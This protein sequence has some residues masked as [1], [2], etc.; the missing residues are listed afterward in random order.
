MI[1]TYLP[2]GPGVVGV[3]KGNIST[4]LYSGTDS[5]ALVMSDCFHYE[6]PGFL[7]KVRLPGNKVGW[8][9][10][11]DGLLRILSSGFDDG[12]GKKIEAI[13]LQC[14]S[15]LKKSVFSERVYSRIV[16]IYSCCVI[17]G[18]VF[19]GIKI[20]EAETRLAMSYQ[21]RDGVVFR[22]D[23][24]RLANSISV[25]F[26]DSIVIKTFDDKGF[27]VGF[28]ARFNE[29]WKM[30]IPSIGRL[31][32]VG[33]NVALYFEDGSD[34]EAPADVLVVN[35]QSGE[36]VWRRSF[37][38]RFRNL[39]SHEGLLYVACQGS[40][41]VF[42]GETGE[43]LLALKDVCEAQVHREM[44]FGNGE[45]V[46]F[47]NYSYTLAREA[48]SER[49]IAVFSQKTSAR[50][51]DIEIPEGWEYRESS[52]DAA[53]VYEDRKFYV[54]IQSNYSLGSAGGIL[55]ID[56]DDLNSEIRFDSDITFDTTM[57]SVGKEVECEVYVSWGDFDEIM[58][59]APPA[60]KAVGVS[61]GRSVLCGK[62]V[63]NK[64]FNGK[65]HL[66]IDASAVE[67]GDWEREQLDMAVS[68][69]TD[70][71]SGLGFYASDGKTE[72]TAHW[73]VA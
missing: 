51:L 60:M 41:Y 56:C 5:V 66:V 55:V 50:I 64:K 63:K 6:K 11:K 40:G 26:E 73:R 52:V 14:E 35:P 61:E 25:V 58:R 18:A 47:V 44:L 68:C 20:E 54:P 45:Y 38:Q 69:V 15:D 9:V 59:Y 12:V 43:Q 16:Q 65:V 71:F 2:A 39:W 46:F 67:L 32:S 7:S 19:L 23:D 1:I 48:T 70:R 28:D 49:T 10:Y 33:G 27:F 36:E 8:V 4:I 30:P 17:R 72:M 24:D 42:D 13:L 37:S 21:Y 3:N 22:V 53:V 31:C 29:L 62:E 34:W 57:V